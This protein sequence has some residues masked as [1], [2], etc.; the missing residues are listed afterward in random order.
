MDE[1]GID[2]SRAKIET[3]GNFLKFCSNVMRNNNG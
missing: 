3:M 1:G 2:F